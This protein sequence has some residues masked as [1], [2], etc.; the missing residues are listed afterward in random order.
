MSN[1]RQSRLSRD[2]MAEGI[3]NSFEANTA[4]P[5]PARRGFPTPAR[6]PRPGVDRIASGLEDAFIYAEENKS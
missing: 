4:G 1:T 5:V 6:D 2:D 3:A